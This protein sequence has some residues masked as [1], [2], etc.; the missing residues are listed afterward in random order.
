M[1]VETETEEVQTTKT[2]T[3]VR[4]VC[5]D[6]DCEASTESADPRGDEAVADPDCDV[7]H[8]INYVALNPCAGQETKYLTHRTKTVSALDDETGVYVCDD[9]L[10]SA[11]EYMEVD[12]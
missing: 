3:T 6:P 2:K 1:P 7:G 9:H 8:N 12:R 10:S 4:Y 5:A 11:M